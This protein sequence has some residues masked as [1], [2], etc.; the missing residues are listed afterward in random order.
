L[1]GF[2]YKGK[3]WINF[4]KKQVNSGNRLWLETL[5]PVEYLQ[6]SVVTYILP[7]LL[8]TGENCER[9]GSA[10]IDNSSC[11]ILI[12]GGSAP[13]EIT[14]PLH[15]AFQNKALSMKKILIVDDDPDTCA[16][17]I[18]LFEKRGYQAWAA[19]DGMEALKIVDSGQPDVVI[20]DLEMEGMD[21]LETYQ[22][23]SARSSIPVIF[24]T[25]LSSAEHAAQLFGLGAR[26]FIEK[27]FQPMDLIE[28]TERVIASSPKDKIVRWQDGMESYLARPRVTVV[29]PALNEEKNLP[30][31]LPYLPCEW[32]DEVLLVDGGSQDNTVQIAQQLLPTIRVIVEPRPGKGA[33]LRTGYSSAQ[34]DI[35]VVIDADGSHDPREIPR[36]IR[37]LMEGADFARGSRF[38]PGGG[39]TDMPRIR[40]FGNGV[41]VWLVNTLYNANFTDITYGFHAF[42]R[43]CLDVFE[44]KDI[45]GFD[46]EPAI[47]IRALRNQMR[48]VDVPSFEG[49]RFMGIPKLQTLPDGWLTLKRI[50]RELR[51]KSNKK[52]GPIFFRDGGRWIQSAYLPIS[53]FNRGT[54]AGMVD[55]LQ[56]G[57]LG[58]YRSSLAGK[59]RTQLQLLSALCKM[60]GRAVSPQDMLGHTLQETLQVLDAA[61]G[62]LLVL[63]ELGC[64]IHSSTIYQGK[65]RPLPLSRAINLME[66]GLARWVIDHREPTVVHSTQ[67]DPRWI[68]PDY[69]VEKGSVRSALSLPLIAS[70]RVVGVLTVSRPG[71]CRFTEADLK[72]LDRL[73]IYY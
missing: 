27:P 52:A 30:L 42:W 67:D 1:L 22:R 66:N 63:D 51:G 9:T 70:N 69:E 72:H 53:R 44:Y 26:D 73:G 65:I 61:S 23:M 14:R 41:F 21:G 40:Q 60:L 31:L 55:F 3:F 62:S 46:F 71:V 8:P 28:R 5:N 48:I 50:F 29:I 18:M 43:Y 4:A 11:F 34:G 6:E 33:A 12:G 2:D 59:P 39:T 68:P 16:L 25:A 38:A 19:Q 58:G 7:V 15:K 37:V 10:L 35:I 20:L 24:L 57:T 64:V 17:V 13:I 56:G 45:D 54:D 36:F 49:E 32:I 47:Y